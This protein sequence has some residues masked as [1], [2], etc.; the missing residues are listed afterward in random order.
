V[1]LFS[2]SAAIA[3]SAILNYDLELIAEWSLSNSLTL[4]PAKFQYLSIGS[5]VL[6]SRVQS[7]YVSYSV[8]LNTL[9]VARI[10]GL[11]VNSSSSFVQYIS[12]KCRA[13][14]LRLH[15]LYPL[16]HILTVS[17]KLHFSQLLILI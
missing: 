4:N 15:L 9:S 6:L 2:P 17:Q 12:L 3:A 8:P 10:L 7:F 11:C 5:S 16:Y 1:K 14:Y 13:V